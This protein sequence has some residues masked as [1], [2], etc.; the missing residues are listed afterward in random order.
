[1]FYVSV[2]IQQIWF[3]INAKHTLLSVKN[4]KFHYKLHVTIP[5]TVYIYRSQVYWI[6]FKINPSKN[7]LTEKKAD[8]IGA[9]LEYSP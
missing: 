6:T 7:V 2:I 1:M 5:S 8:E 9:M 4:R 3:D